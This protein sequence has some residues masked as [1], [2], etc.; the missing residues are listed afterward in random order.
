[1]ARRAIGAA[2]QP[3]DLVRM[4]QRLDKHYGGYGQRWQVETVFSMIKRRLA[5]AVQARRYQSQCRELWL[6]ALTYN[7]I[8]V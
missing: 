2:G 1:M 4:R 5:N 6:L 8:L 3:R 7:L